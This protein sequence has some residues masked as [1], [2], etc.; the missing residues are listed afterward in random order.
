MAVSIHVRQ[1]RRHALALRVGTRTA[2]ALLGG[3]SSSLAHALLLT[4][5]VRHV[6]VV[7]TP[8]GVGTRLVIITERGDE[9]S[10]LLRGRSA[11]R[12]VVMVINTIIT[13]IIDANIGTDRRHLA[14]TRER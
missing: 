6:V 1:W 3:P 11:K 12:L 8:G 7:V 9:L 4:A 10:S 5:I 13:T 2:A 14:Q